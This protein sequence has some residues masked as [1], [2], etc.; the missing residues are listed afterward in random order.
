ARAEAN[1]AAR[2]ELRVTNTSDEA[3][4]PTE[5]E[6]RLN[7]A[8]PLRSPVRGLAPR[9]ST[10]VRFDVPGPLAVGTHAFVARVDPDQPLPQSNRNDDVASGRV[11][12][13]PAPTLPD[14]AVL[15]TVGRGHADPPE[16]VA[17]VVDVGPVASPP[18]QAYL[19]LG[20][21]RVSARKVPA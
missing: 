1:R 7:G 8:A 13:R 12:V 3:A 9:A 14:L 10:E 17:L 6:L 16:V 20:G 15:R 4:A 5:I 11:E 2:V 19:V 18:A 21:K